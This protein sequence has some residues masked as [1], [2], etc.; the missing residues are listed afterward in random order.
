M[1]ERFPFAIAMANA[2]DEIKAIASYS[3][4]SNT[5][6]G[7]AKVLQALNEAQGSSDVLKSFQN[8]KK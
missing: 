4:A 2:C 7:V 3:T 1:F 5:E 8:F 6:H